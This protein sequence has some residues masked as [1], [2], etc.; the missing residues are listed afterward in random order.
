MEETRRNIDH[1]TRTICSVLHI[2]RDS[3]GH[4]KRQRPFEYEVRRVA[5]IMDVFVHGK[6]TAC[7][8]G[9]NVAQGRFN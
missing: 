3:S 2:P 1:V 9:Q 5:V 6:A 4:P 7:K 8:D